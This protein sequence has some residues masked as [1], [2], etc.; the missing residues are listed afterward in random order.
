MI[1]INFHSVIQT[2]NALKPATKHSLKVENHFWF[3]LW[4]IEFDWESHWL[5]TFWITF[6]FD[7][8]FIRS[9]RSKCPWTYSSTTATN[10]WHIAPSK[11][12]QL[13]FSFNRIYF[14]RNVLIIFSLNKISPMTIVHHTIENPKAMQVNTKNSKNHKR[15]HSS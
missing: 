13:L 10:Q 14:F 4:N 5:A 8:H 15:L 3:F 12:C 7:F 2:L 6:S 1:E 9:V 11:N